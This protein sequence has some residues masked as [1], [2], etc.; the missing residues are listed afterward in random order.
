MLPL[1]KQFTCLLQGEHINKSPEIPTC[2]YKN[3]KERHK[4]CPLNAE[5]NSSYLSKESCRRLPGTPR[6]FSA[7]GEVWTLFCS[8]ILKFFFE[9]AVIV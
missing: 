5:R 3:S 4:T 8:Q 7:F 1:P 2:N 9:R 6:H